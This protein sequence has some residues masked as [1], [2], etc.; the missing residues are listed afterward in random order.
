MSEQKDDSTF[1]KTIVLKR[2]TEHFTVCRRV[3]ILNFIEFVGMYKI[4]EGVM[5][6]V[7]A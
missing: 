5:F 1:V 3:G 7:F 2:V 6:G 4:Q